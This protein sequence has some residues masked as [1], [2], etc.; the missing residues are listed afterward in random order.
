MLVL[1]LLAAAFVLIG[2]GLR[3]L[4][5]T[6]LRDETV[7]MAAMLR[8]A[9]NMATFSGVHHRVV[10][11]L[12][13]QTFRIEACPGDQKLY[14]S[15]EE[16]VPDSERI[17]A[18]ME[19]LEER[20]DPTADQLPEIIGAETPEQAIEAA[21]ALEGVQLGTARCSVPRTPNNHADGRGNLR[22][23]RNDK[24]KIKAIHVAHLE[25]PVTDGEASINFFPLG[26]S[27]KAVIIMADD[28]DNEMVLLVHRLTGI[29]EW[30]RGDYDPDDH[31]R[32]NAVGDSE[33]DERDTGRLR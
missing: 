19:K 31:M 11:N 21:A 33:D 8:S 14:R 22:E 32:R 15:E 7:R 27:E 25:D 29:V 16:P 26:T 2:G 10:F 28:R 12:E 24:V 30:K 9:Y 17:K 4:N 20:R 13:N 23:I 6:D 3:R 18:L 5:K 1:A